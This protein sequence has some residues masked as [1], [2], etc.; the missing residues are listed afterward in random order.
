[1]RKATVGLVQQK[2][3]CN[4]GRTYAVELGQIKTL[5]LINLKNYL[6]TCGNNP[7]T[8]LLQKFGGEEEQSVVE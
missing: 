4:W 1:M 5:I 2:Y 3:C 6:K 8:T 7:A